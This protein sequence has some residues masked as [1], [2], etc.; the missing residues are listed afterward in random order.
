MLRF[1]DWQLFID[2]S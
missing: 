2:V 1:V